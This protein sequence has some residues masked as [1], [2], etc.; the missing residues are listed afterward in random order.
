M[1]IPPQFPPLSGLK[2]A[3]LAAGLKQ[4]DLERLSGVSQSIITKVE[5]EQRSPRYETAVK[6]FTA[7]TK[8][9]EDQAKGDTRKASEIMTE[10]VKRFQITAIVSVV[11]QRMKNDDISQ[12]PVYD[13]DALVGMVTDRSLLGADPEDTLKNYLVDA[14]PVISQN[15]PV[16]ALERILKVYSAVLLSN[17][18]G[19]IVGICSRQDILPE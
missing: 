9:L 12:F 16:H 13:G 11:I 10:E 1:Y 6:L 17:K 4:T 7:I 8:H 19:K 18:S 3:R 2:T 5:R 15:T 14:L